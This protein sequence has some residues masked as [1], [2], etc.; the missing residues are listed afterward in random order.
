ME[1]LLVPNVMARRM[2]SDFL[3]ARTDA[4]KAE[5]RAE[6]QRRRQQKQ[7]QQQQSGAGRPVGQPQTGGL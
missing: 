2:V 5:L 7:Q 1:P 3:Q 6:R 4:R